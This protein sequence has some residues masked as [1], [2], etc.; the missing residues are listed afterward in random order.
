MS[1]SNKEVE[2]F[3]NQLIEFRIDIDGEAFNIRV[4]LLNPFKP[5]ML[6]YTLMMFTNFYVEGKFS[7][8]LNSGKELSLSVVEPKELIEYLDING[9]IFN[10]DGYAEARKKA[11]D[12]CEELGRQNKGETFVLKKEK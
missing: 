5:E 11:K 8:F 12:Y 2:N 3:A 9:D 7:S 1:S 10:I 6:S 4:L